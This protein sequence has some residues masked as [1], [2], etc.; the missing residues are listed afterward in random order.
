MYKGRKA[1]YEYANQPFGKKDEHEISQIK[2]TGASRVEVVSNGSYYDPMHLLS[3]GYWAWSEKMA[4][5]LPYDFKPQTP[6]NKK[7]QP[8]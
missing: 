6:A 3:F 5:M 4:N 8:L 1:P 7:S 2:L